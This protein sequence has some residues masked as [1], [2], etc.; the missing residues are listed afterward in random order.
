MS[1]YRA[2]R[3]ALGSCCL[4]DTKF[5]K[6]LPFSSVQTFDSRLVSFLQGLGQA[7]DTPA[8]DAVSGYNIHDTLFALGFTQSDRNVRLQAF[9]NEL[10]YSIEMR[11]KAVQSSLVLGRNGSGAYLLGPAGGVILSNLPLNSSYNLTAATAN[12]TSPDEIIV[13]D[14]GLTFSSPIYV[15]HEVGDTKFSSSQPL[16]V[17]GQKTYADSI[18]VPNGIQSIVCAESSNPFLLSWSRSLSRIVIRGSDVTPIAIALQ[19]PRPRNRDYYPS[20]SPVLP[21]LYCLDELILRI[22]FDSDVALS[23][24]VYVTITAGSIEASIFIGDVTYFSGHAYSGHTYLGADAILVL[25]ARTQPLAD[26][27]VR[28]PGSLPSWRVDAWF[29]PAGI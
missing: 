2:I 29:E 4:G 25:R 5:A 12:L 10:R 14:A 23:S 20:V 17:L 22:Q 8:S 18:P 9:Y 19:L 3:N 26:D 13:N 16:F 27:Y 7:V 1:L 15:K 11:Q 21:A 28:P 6:Q 24:G